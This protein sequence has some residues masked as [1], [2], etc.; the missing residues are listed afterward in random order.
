MGGGGGVGRLKEYHSPPP[1]PPPPPPLPK[2][3][4]YLPLKFPCPLPKYFTRKNTA[5]ACSFLLFWSKCPQTE[6]P[7]VENTS[8]NAKQAIASLRNVLPVYM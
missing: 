6:G 5:F 4:A 8:E 7:L 1:S 2:M 3:L